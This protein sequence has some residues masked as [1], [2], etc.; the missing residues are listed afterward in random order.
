M[1]KIVAPISSILARTRIFK[2]S[3]YL[4]G[5]NKEFSFWGWE[6]VIGESKEEI[7]HDFDRQYLISGGG[8]GGRLTYLYYFYWV[9]KVFF[10]T[11]FDK[12]D[13]YYCLGFESAFPVYMASKFR[14]LSYFYDDA[15]RFSMIF[16]EN[17]RILRNIEQL[18][19]K[20]STVHIVP[21]ILRY[22]DFK[23][24]DK[25]MEV[26]NFPSETQLCLAETVEPKEIVKQKYPYFNFDSKIVYVNG[27]ISNVRGIDILHEVAKSLI[28]NN[29]NINFI[30][31]GKVD[32]DEGR[33]FIALDNVFYIGNLKNHEAISIYEICDYVFTYYRP[34][35][36]INLFAESNKWGD[37]LV[38]KVKIIV[39][40]EVITAND[41]I[42]DGF[43]RGF[44][45]YDVESLTEYLKGF[46]EEYPTQHIETYSFEEKLNIVFDKL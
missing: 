35:S 33:R 26:K 14:K 32:T 5:K 38:K 40:S 13:N 30:V 41:L 29:E 21:N 23:C 39:N 27:W 9:F 37:A 42:K 16:G 22:P 43:A 17:A 10:K 19:S 12:S 46:N 34:D 1:I 2:L 45:Y 36:K 31:A 6:R 28:A 15:D 25:I 44:S 3:Q 18:V 11:L 7:K 4:I 8:Y 24:I 20:N